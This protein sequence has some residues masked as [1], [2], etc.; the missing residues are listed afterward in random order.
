M[1]K[2]KA[3][4]AHKQHVTLNV[5]HGRPT[6]TGAAGRA[7]EVQALLNSSFKRAQKLAQH[8]N[9]ELVSQGPSDF[10]EMGPS[11]FSQIVATRLPKMS[12]AQ[13]DRARRASELL[14]RRDGIDA[15][16][17]YQ[18]RLKAFEDRVVGGYLK[19]RKGKVPNRTFTA[20]ELV[21]DIIRKYDGGQKNLVIDEVAAG[22][23][24]QVT[25][26]L[27]AIERHRP[28]ILKGVSVYM[29]SGPSTGPKAYPPKLLK[30]LRDH[31]MRVY[32]ETYGGK[33]G[34]AWSD[35]QWDGTIESIRKFRKQGVRMTPMM[36]LAS[37]HIGTGDDAKREALRRAKYI[38]KRTGFIPSIWHMTS[39]KSPSP[40]GLGAAV[41]R[42]M[43]RVRQN[44]AR[45]HQATKENR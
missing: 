27:D 32:A 26:A 13:K 28:E 4:P 24:P 1:A 21:H 44:S 45:L 23:A 15:E 16:A 36:S 2:L 3:P 14:A 22:T 18:R 38:Y 12:E 37:Q 31:R 41:G 20:K 43:N 25:K 40:K 19:H 34:K 6:A 8:P 35:K 7:P 42:W 33:A 11:D 17:E 10:Y 5:S 9:V 39:V 30:L 29:V